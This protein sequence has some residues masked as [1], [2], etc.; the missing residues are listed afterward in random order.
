MK[1]RVRVM[2]VMM[3]VLLAAA[4][5]GGCGIRGKNTAK[6][7]GIT[8]EG[9]EEKSELNNAGRAEEAAE[10]PQAA[11]DSVGNTAEYSAVA[12][13]GVGNTEE[14]S[15]VAENGFQNVAVNPLSTFGAD[16]DTASY[17]NIR[18][19]LMEGRT[20]ADIPKGAVRIEEML[21][22]FHYDYELPGEEEIFG[23]TIDGADCPWQKEHGLIRIGVRTQ[24]LDFSQSPKSNLVFLLDVSGSMDEPGKL[25]LLKQAFSMLVDNLGE[26]DRISIVTYAGADQVVLD[27]A[28]GDEK[29]VI[30][31][32][33]NALT[34]GGGTNGS[35]GIETA[36]A[37]AEKYFLPGGNNRV[38]LATDGDLNIGSTSE[39]QLKT[40]VEEKRKGGVYLSVLGFGQGNLKD[41]KL[42]TLADNGNGNYAYVDSLMEAK[43]V[44]VDEMG[45]TL[46][47]VAEDVKLQLEFNPVWISEYRLLGYENR[48]LAAEDFADDTKD[49]GEVGAGHTVTVLYEVVWA[50]EE[51]ADSQGNTALKYQTVEPS[52]GEAMK[53]WATLKIRYKE[54]GKSKSKE[55]VRTF[56]EEIYKEDIGKADMLLEASVAELGLLLSDS[57]WK[58]NASYGQIVELWSGNQYGG[59]EEIAEFLELVGLAAAGDGELC[60]YPPY[61]P[62]TEPGQGAQSGITFS[63]KEGTLTPSGATFLLKNNFSED[64]WYGEHY[65]LE[66]AQGESWVQLV[67]KEGAAWHDIAYLLSAG[68][69]NEMEIAWEWAYG[70]LPVGTYRIQTQVYPGEGEV[71][72]REITAMVEFEIF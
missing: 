53:E 45:S 37:M 36:Y 49:A 28:R 71:T 35:A 18:R 61:E 58:G 10:S 2:S 26:K 62:E 38:I 40:I 54:P 33:L 67:P 15:A 48:L 68:A 32:A 51:G 46:V 63:V 9:S 34:A 17:S 14:Y 20:P 3:A 59:S 16:V 57:A 30:L 6:A 60:G 25:P 55:I 39:S 72:G 56:G 70:K 69:E 42:K 1:N 13:R 47:T 52:S 8:S 44:L 21:N 29:D 66:R 31:D 43:R 12:E 5:I 27:G 64:Y 41:N 23:I 7:D 19:M 11:M 50:G 24:E 65:T 22:Y 4:G